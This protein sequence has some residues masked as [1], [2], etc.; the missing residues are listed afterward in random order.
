MSHHRGKLK[1]V[2]A[3][4]IFNHGATTHTHDYVHIS[5]S[6]TQLGSSESSVFWY[7]NDFKIITLSTCSYNLFTNIFVI[8][9]F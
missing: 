6:F 2:I 5:N 7:D 8:V 4:D 9:I 3:P 1:Q